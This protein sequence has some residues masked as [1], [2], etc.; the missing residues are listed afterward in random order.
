MTTQQRIIPT[1]MLKTRL[2]EKLER[3]LTPTVNKI[4]L[5]IYYR[6]NLLT[7]M[8]NYIN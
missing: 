8:N 3:N 2:G 5:F 1:D 6:Y 4:Q 7:I